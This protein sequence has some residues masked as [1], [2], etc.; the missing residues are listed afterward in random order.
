MKNNVKY[1]CKVY[2][3][4]TFYKKIILTD[5]LSDSIYDLAR[6]A[7]KFGAIRVELTIVEN[8]HLKKNEV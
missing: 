5:S 6:W 3:D 8:L 7:T 1:V 2:F 4:D